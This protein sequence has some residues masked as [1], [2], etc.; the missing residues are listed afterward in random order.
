MSNC[1]NCQNL[2]DEDF[3]LVTCS[4]CGST[5]FVELDGSLRTNENEV[6]EEVAA[7][8]DMAVTPSDSTS[9]AP[10]TDEFEPQGGN[11]ETFSESEAFREGDFE[12]EFYARAE[13]EAHGEK[14][15]GGEAH[16]EVVYEEAAHGEAVHEEAVH[17]EAAHE[18]AAHEEAVHG[19]AA[20][21]GEVIEERAFS[22]EGNLVAN[23]NE[24]FSDEAQGEPE[25]QESFSVEE[26]DEQVA[27]DNSPPHEEVTRGEW[28]ED[29]WSGG[30]SV[31]PLVEEPPAE[32]VSTDF[33]DISE[34]GNS[35]ISGAVEG[36]LRFNVYISGIDSSEILQ[37][38]R[39]SLLDKQFM[40]DV[41]ELIGSIQN[42]KLELRDISAVKASIVVNRL[43]SM[44]VQIHWEQ[45]AIN[46]A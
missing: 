17:G 15:H 14:V 12:G 35:S 34:Y 4:G 24:L 16:G 18:E 43:K 30:E 38:I 32:K 37:F 20:H 42:G 13:G 28:L 44:S 5:L 31:E 27:P 23:E 41:D 25:L 2:I 19:E 11:P 29:D 40:W 3:G 8:N 22:E 33:S 10:M 39:E 36:F 6:V 26:S 46:Q 45:Y 7:A 9:T 1:P 21:G